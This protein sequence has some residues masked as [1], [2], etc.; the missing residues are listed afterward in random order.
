MAEPISSFH[1]PGPPP[2]HAALI[3]AEA[4]MRHNDEISA[5]FVVTPGMPGEND[6]PRDVVTILRVADPEQVTIGAELQG[7]SQIHVPHWARV[8]LD[9]TEGVR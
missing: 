9:S 8:L 5:V 3:A 4:T 6:L 1:V 7:R 2:V